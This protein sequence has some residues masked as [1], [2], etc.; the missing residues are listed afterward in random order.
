MAIEAELKAVRPTVPGNIFESGTWVPKAWSGT[1]LW[2][3]KN[4]ALQQEVSSG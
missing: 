2:P 1:S 3:V 4:Q